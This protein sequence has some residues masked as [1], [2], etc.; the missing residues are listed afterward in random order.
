MSNCFIVIDHDEIES[1]KT[2]DALRLFPHLNCLGVYK[3]DDAIFELLL[4][5]KPTLVFIAANS[6][7]NGHG[8]LSFES[9]ARIHE[10]LTDY[11]YFIYLSHTD[12]DA[13]VAIQSGFSDY[14]LTPL[15]IHLLGSSL[16]RFKNRVP[17]KKSSYLSVKSYSDYKFIKYSEIVFLK[18]DNNTTDI[19]LMDGRTVVALK[20]L[21][22]FQENLPS[23]FIRIHKSY[24]V[25]IAAVQRIHLSQA[26][27]YLNNGE[28]IPI[29]PNYKNSLEHI[30]T[31]LKL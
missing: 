11:I 1:K 19:I 10:Y 14:L 27:C 20:T 25:H 24:I 18:A 26:K 4:T 16:S 28:V 12:K 17:E 29:S 15:K 13:L 9:I 21:K 2:V 5:K 7:Q 6:M 3:N 30:L 23:L 22:Y 31:H 8:P